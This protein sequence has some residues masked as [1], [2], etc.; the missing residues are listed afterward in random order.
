M[1]KHKKAKQT[2]SGV[3][4]LKIDGEPLDL[5]VEAPK[6]LT[7]PIRMLPV[8]RSVCG[9]VVDWT[10]QRIEREGRSISCKA[11]CG[12]CCR[13]MVPI[14]KTE[15]HRLAEIVDE[16]PDERRHAVRERFESAIR[17]F[18]DANLIEKLRADSKATD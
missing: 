2:L 18:T 13:Q 1:V 5:N 9:S 7:R 14:S 3:L 4:S 6:T 10:V 12:A 16:M 8:F 11:G 17:H 15:A